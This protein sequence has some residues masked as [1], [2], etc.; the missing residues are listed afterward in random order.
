LAKFWLSLLTELSNR[1]PRDILIR[2]RDGLSG[3]LEAITTAF[4]SPP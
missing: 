1:G 2:C 4:P 3:L